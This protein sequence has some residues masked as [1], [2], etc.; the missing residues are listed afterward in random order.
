MKY[1]GI[2]CFALLTELA[3]VSAQATM[4]EHAQRATAAGIDVITYQSGVKNVVSIAGFLPAGDAMAD[5]A[6][7]AVAT[8]SGMMLDRGTLSRDKFAIAQQ[9]DDVG[10][11][12]AF[13]VGTQSLS[14]SAK[15]LKHDLSMVIGLIADE[16]RN[17]KLQAEEF[18]K[19][20]QQLIGSIQASSQSTD[21]RAHEAFTRAAFPAG[22]PN[23]PAGSAEMLASAKRVTLED[24]RAF[25]AKYYG[26][27]HMTLVLVGDV[28]ATAQEQIGKAFAG[29]KGGQSFIRVAHAASPAAADL[30]VP[31]SDKPSVSVILG[32]PTGLQY[33]DADALALRVGTAILGHGFTGRLMSTVR[34]KE[35]LTYGIG[36]GVADDSIVDGGWNISAT[37]APALLDK[38]IASTRRELQ[39]WWQDGVTE[40]ELSDRKQ[41]LIGGYQVGLAS[42]A[43]I[44]AAIV[45]ALQRGYD[46]S[47]LDQYPEAVRALTVEQINHS[48]R[49]H[50]DPTKM[51]LVRAGSVGTPIK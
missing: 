43:G 28:D 10:A 7:P 50:L 46:L 22:H 24:V 45:S 39:H 27:E 26:P 17:P 19:A 36:A 1:F 47:W 25:Q 18:A 20:K 15:C 49:A 48:I 6:N 37:F 11:S 21:A 51:V 32:Q 29:W 33:R 8:L 40:R 44:A 31:L 4:L 16:L 23:H 41:G 12:I 3:A 30:S 13:N 35:G 34:D 5:A 2:V 9:L 38:G 42:S 14:I